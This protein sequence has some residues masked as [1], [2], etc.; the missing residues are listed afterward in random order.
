MKKRKDNLKTAVFPGSFDPVTNGHL[1]VIVRAQ[2]LFDRLIIAV[3]MNERK[4]SLFSVDERKA[5][6][7]SVCRNFK[8][9]E[10]AS[11]NGLLVDAV[12]VFN[13]T[14]VVRGLRAIS[15]FEYEFQMAMMNRELD[16]EFETV[17]LMPSPEYSFV[18][19]RIIK[20]IVRLGGDV[21]AFVPAEV[22]RA[23]KSKKL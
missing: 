13:A 3:A 16:R 15:D 5:L 1:D 18:S 17:F 12:K 22:I 4:C 20:E 8:N 9:V 21:S 6:L 14:A 2:R 11:F 7:D 10:I 19:S 23:L